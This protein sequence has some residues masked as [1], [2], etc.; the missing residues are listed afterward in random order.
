VAEGEFLAVALGLFFV[1]GG[2]DE[3]VP[4][5]SGSGGLDNAAVGGGVGVECDLGAMK[6]RVGHGS[7]SEQID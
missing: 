3:V 6:E 7:T 5:V 1:G 4:A 2:E